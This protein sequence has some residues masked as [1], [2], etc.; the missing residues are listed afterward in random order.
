M[1]NDEPMTDDDPGDAGGPRPT[2]PFCASVDVELESP[3]GGEVSK[4]RY[5]CNSCRTVFE[6][7]KYDGRRP[8]TGR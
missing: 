5:Y 7:L 6:R 4:T 3:F 8:G 1:A 2:C